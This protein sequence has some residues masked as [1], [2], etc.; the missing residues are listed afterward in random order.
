MPV[1]KR[2]KVTLA[3]AGAL[4]CFCLSLILWAFVIE[5]D[6]LVVN[7]VVI[8]L[9][10]WPPAFEHLK[11]VL[12]SDLHVGSPH[13]G[14]DK[15]QQVVATINRQNPDLILI[16]GDFVIQDVVG[17]NFVEPEVIAD[18]LKDLRARLGVFAVLGNHDWW[19]DGERVHRAISGA[20][21]RVLENDVAEI[22]QD[23]QSLWLVG[24]ADLWTQKPDIEGS[25]QK[26]SDAG[27]VIVLTHNPDLFPRIPARV[28]LTL[29]GHTHGGQINL[30][31]FG[32]RIVPSDYGERY[33]IGHIQEAGH[34]LFVTPGIGTS[35]IPVR[36]R[37]PPEISIL[38]LVRST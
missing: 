17:G 34:H 38:I 26:V 37:V 6:R 30:P 10:Q 18:K 27:P 25:L 22:Q 7:E 35:I 4:L 16:A 8:G 12:I 29:A 14:V 32:R 2:K 3:V 15:L 19:Y 21:I 13:V 11:I 23:G 31:F 1:S 20:G 36:F 5:P 33:A 24:L 28:I 9:P